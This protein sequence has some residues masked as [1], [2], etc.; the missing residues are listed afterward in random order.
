MLG[1]LPLLIIILNTAG[2][3]LSA[4]PYR[5]DK[6]RQFITDVEE[7]HEQLDEAN[8]QLAIATDLN[9]Q[10][11][12]MLG[13]SQLANIST[14]VQDPFQDIQVCLCIINQY[15]TTASKETLFAFYEGRNK[16]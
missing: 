2:G 12:S 4:Q 7:L 11:L 14:P 15:P 1:V 5:P 10:L 6:I 16:L 13:S 8:K 3:A 9:M